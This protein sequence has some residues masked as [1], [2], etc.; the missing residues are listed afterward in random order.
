MTLLQKLQEI[1]L[2]EI[3]LEDVYEHTEIIRLLYLHKALRGRIDS[4]GSLPDIRAFQKVLDQMLDDMSS[5]FSDT[6]GQV[7]YELNMLQKSCAWVTNAKEYREKVKYVM[8]HC[9]KKWWN[10]TI[11]SNMVPKKMENERR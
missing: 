5:N 6:Q 9:L 10:I 11:Y 4:I 1:S 8:D 3:A 7:G 2:E